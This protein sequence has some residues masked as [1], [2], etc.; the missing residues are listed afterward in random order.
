M[1]GGGDEA[2]EGI[3]FDGRS[4]FVE[5]EVEAVGGELGEGLVEEGGVE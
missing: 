5:E 3:G 2:E 4:D 1:T